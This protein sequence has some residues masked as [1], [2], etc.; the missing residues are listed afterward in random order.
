MTQQRKPTILI[1][2][3]TAAGKTALAIALAQRLPGGGECISADSMQVYRRMDIGTAKPSAQQRQAVPHHLL[4]VADP[5]DDSFSVD[6]WL[7]LARHAI[8]DVAGRLRYPIVVGG[9]NLY[10]QALLYGLADMPEPHEP[11]RARLQGMDLTALRAWLERVDPSAAQRIHPNDRKRTVRAIEVF[12]ATGHQLSSLQTQWKASADD[13][14][15]PP[16]DRDSIFIIGLNYPVE[17]INRRINARVKGMI[18]AGLIDEVRR[19]HHAG[20][21]G[22]NAREALGYKQVLEYLEGHCTLEQAIEHIKIK[23]RRF[24]KQQRSWLRRF[25]IFQPSV[26]IDAGDLSPEEIAQRAIS[27]LSDRVFSR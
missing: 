2:G 7:E 8:R 25:K 12:E 21:L 16:Q 4:D 27:V 6:R 19:L 10:V 26:W 11:L 24:A 13:P 1:L 14:K 18:D 23:T 17:V 5:S 22:Q 9:T 20:A 15:L 3:P